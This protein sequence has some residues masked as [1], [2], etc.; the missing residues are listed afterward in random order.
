MSTIND[1]CERCG[2]DLEIDDRDF[3]LCEDCGDD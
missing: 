1:T 3:H 2:C